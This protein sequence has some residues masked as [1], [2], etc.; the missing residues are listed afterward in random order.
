M[1]RRAIPLQL[2]IALFAPQ[3]INWRGHRMEALP[4]GGLR[5]IRRRTGE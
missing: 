2:L 5:F 4:G 1:I 3:Q